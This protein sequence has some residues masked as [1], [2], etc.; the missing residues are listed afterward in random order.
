MRAFSTTPRVAIDAGQNEE[1][2]IDG[3]P[4][5]GNRMGGV[6]APTLD[7]ANADQ[8]SETGAVRSAQQSFV[9]AEKNATR[10]A[11]KDAGLLNEATVDTATA[12]DLKSSRDRR[13]LE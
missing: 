2:G 4:N 11:G 12:E 6:A 10:D 3:N 5:V 1:I 8:E 13:N 7:E 9:D